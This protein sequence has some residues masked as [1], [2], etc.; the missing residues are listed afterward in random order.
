MAAL[1][2][3]IDVRHMEPASLNGAF[4]GKMAPSAMRTT[5]DVRCLVTV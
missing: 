2:E 3:F 4:P 5:S 1:E